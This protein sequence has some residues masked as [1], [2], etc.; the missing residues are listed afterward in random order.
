MKNAIKKIAAIAMAFTLLGTGT[1]VTKTIAPQFDN[2]IIA[3]AATCYNCHEGSYN[4]YT[5]ETI[6]D[7]YMVVGFILI[8]ITCKY[9]IEECGCCEKEISK[10]LI[11]W[12][13]K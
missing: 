10:T 1:A 12:K 6:E 2:S 9:R 8:P 11:K 5:Y 7:A 3:S 4:T 13:F